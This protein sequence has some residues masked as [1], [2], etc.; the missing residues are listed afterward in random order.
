MNWNDTMP[1]TVRDLNPN[2]D[3][4]M[5]CKECGKKM[6][7]GEIQVSGDCMI[8]PNCGEWERFEKVEE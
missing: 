3:F 4:Y 7:I 1:L 2:L 8:C 5:V 6:H